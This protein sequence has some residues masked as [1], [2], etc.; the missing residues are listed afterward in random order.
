MISRLDL[1]AYRSDQVIGLILAG[2]AG[3]RMGGKDK[4]L[5]E[6]KGRP[7]V[8]WVAEALRPQVK[9]LLI[10]ANRHQERYAELGWPVIA[11]DRPIDQEASSEIYQGPL[12][13]IAAALNWLQMQPQDWINRIQTQ[14]TDPTPDPSPDPVESDHPPAWLLISPCDTPLIPTDLGSRLAAALQSQQARIAIAADQARSQPLHLL[15][16]TD[17]GADLEDYLDHGRRSVL[18]WLERHQIATATFKQS[19][20][21]FSN[22]NRPA[23]AASIHA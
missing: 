15:L 21:P 23:D 18:G 13:G 22:L 20:S 1:H 5:I 7:L 12:A 8:Q 17:I 14:Q 3:Q 6:L 4:G 10:S 9:G 19:P 2:G 11:D 16:P